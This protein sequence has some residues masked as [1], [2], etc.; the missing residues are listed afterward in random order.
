MTYKTGDEAQPRLAYGTTDAQG[1]FELTTFEDRDGAVEGNH[2]VTI[3][4]LEQP[5]M[6]QDPGSVPPGGPTPPPPKPKSLIPAKYS[7]FGT[8]GLT[9]TVS[10]SGDNES[11]FELT[12]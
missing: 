6:G 9:A 8:S 3:L 5:P 10:S 4:K 11:T 12:D 2:T 7:D 1:H